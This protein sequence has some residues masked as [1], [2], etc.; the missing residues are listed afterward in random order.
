MLLQ[1]RWRDSLYCPHCHSESVINYGSYRLF[2]RYRCKDCGCTF[3]DKTGTIFAHAKIDLRILAADRG[4]DAKSFRN[5][6][7]ENGI[8]PLIKHRIYSSLD[9][10]HN[11]RMDSDRYHQRTMSET[12]FS[13][14]SARSAQSWAKVVA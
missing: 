10:T 14:T 2:Q 3:T 4:Y 11:A 13:S 8:R 9:R 12:L 1:V 5:E 6:L 7:R